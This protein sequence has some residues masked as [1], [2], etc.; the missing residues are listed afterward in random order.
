MTTFTEGEV[1]F[2]QSRGNEACR[3]IWLGSFDSRAS[4]LPDSQDPQKVKE[5]LQEKYEK[6]RWYVSPDQAKSL[7]SSS[8]QSSPAE[9][10]TLLGESAAKAPQVSEKAPPQAAQ[11]AKKA[12]T[13]LLADIGGDPF[14]APQ[15]GPTFP[16]FGGQVPA[17]TAFPSFDAFGGSP[18]GLTFGDPLA[19]SQSP[20]QSQPVAA[21]G[22][23]VAAFPASPASQPGVG[24]PS[25]GGAFRVGGIPSS[26]FG[27]LSQSSVLP[28]SSPAAAF[29]VPT[30]TNPFAAP[31]ATQP[32]LPSTNPFQTN[33][34]A[35]GTFM[36]GS[37]GGF[38]ASPLSGAFAS[39]L[40]QEPL[41]FPTQG[42][43]GQPHNGGSS[44]GGFPAARDGQRPLG[45]PAGFSTNPF[46]NPM[47]AAPSPPFAL[48]KHPPT[49]PFS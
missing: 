22:A 14:A 33:G 42:V 16:A 21:G 24:I 18:A 40:Q 27:T 23:H 34:L 43:V 10:K 8:V 29:G 47:A 38:S 25:L 36:V 28:P 2:L 48:A 11:P 13:D 49:N 31:A 35:P 3:K 32:A 6:K 37:P 45:P 9:A 20:F 26:V 15:P 7:A 39:P 17:R 4:L 19:S 12:S 41:F 46:V 5:F 44:F 30:C 1:Q